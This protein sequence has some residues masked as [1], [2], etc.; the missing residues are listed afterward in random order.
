MEDSILKRRIKQGVLL[1]FSIIFLLFCILYIVRNNESKGFS[2]TGERYTKIV[3][4]DNE[5]NLIE[6]EI[7]TTNDEKYCSASSEINDNQ[8]IY[9]P[10]LN[11]I[12][13]L[14]IP[15]SKQYVYF[16][17]VD[18]NISTPYSLDNMLVDVMIKEK[19]YVPNGSVK[20]FSNSFKILGDTDI[21]LY[22]DSSYISI[23]GLTVKAL[24][25]GESL[26]YVLNDRRV[27]KTVKYVTTDLI[28]E[29][30][31][32]FD[33]NKPHLS[34]NQFSEDESNLL[35]EILADRVNEAGYGTRA[36]AV[37]AARF[38][39]LE[40]PYRI[41]Y[42]YENGRVNKTGTN[43]V[44]GEGR[45]Y[46]R[47]LYLNEDK[48]K[49]I[50]ASLA[51]PS[52]W[53]CPLKNYE[54]DEPRFIWGRKY[55]NGLDCSGF[56][57]WALYNGGLDPGDIGTGQIPNIS[58]YVPITDSLISSDNIKVGDLFSAWWHISILVGMDDNN[59]YIAESLPT[60]DGVVVKKYKKKDVHYWFSHVVLMDDFYNGDGNLTNLWY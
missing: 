2:T 41:S 58:D 6:V 16:K 36:G 60:L 13:H 52:I 19:Y 57:T 10:I 30:P 12:C 14:F 42:F 46:H 21:S 49:D 26:I 28:L 59:Y 32:S 1:C 43:Y 29:A 8:L 5:K 34:C 20:D 11:N 7:Q 37:A 31:L 56:V 40:F 25:N 35:D 33:E 3:N 22:T 48:F 17:K 23:D 27:V 24:E 47:G 9:E 51:G 15:F 18:G 38:L 55:P 39:T 54:P 44:D 50:E 45:Y 53:G 4:Y